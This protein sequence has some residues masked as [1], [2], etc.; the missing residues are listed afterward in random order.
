MKGSTSDAR[1]NAQGLLDASATTTPGRLCSAIMRAAS[2][3]SESSCTIGNCSS[4]SSARTMSP[5]DQISPLGEVA[6][7]QVAER[8]QERHECHCRSSLGEVPEGHGMA[9]SLGDTDRDDVRARADR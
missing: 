2:M 9:G 8:Q 3:A 6:Q 5:Y 7:P 1:M 4:R